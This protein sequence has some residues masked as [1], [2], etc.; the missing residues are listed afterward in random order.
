M[1]EGAVRHSAPIQPGDARRQARDILAGRRYDPRDVPRP[2][3]RILN[4]LGD[5]LRPIGHVFTRAV[6][7][8]PSGL[9]PFA[10]LAI[11]A[12]GAV[13]VWLVARTVQN[14][15]RPPR[16]E[17]SELDELALDEPD[18]LERL[19]AEALAR[20]D[21]ESALR[22]RFRAGLVRLDRDAH[23]IEYRASLANGPVRR[24]LASVRFDGLAD[25]F[26]AVTYGDE[27]ATADAAHTAEQRWPEVVREARR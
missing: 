10:W 19:A 6:H 25:T 9:R 22:L 23:A 17:E 7:S 12:I 27:P 11:G 4:W 24:Q 20:G 3:R 21:F 14:R 5:R 26:E 18:D 2:L 8:L 13:V 16:T 1:G 15:I